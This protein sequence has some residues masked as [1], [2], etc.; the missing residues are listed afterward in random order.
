M[1]L[2]PLGSEKRHDRLPIWHHTPKT[3]FMKTGDASD[4]V[5]HAARSVL[6][7]GSWHKKLSG[8]KRSKNM[9]LEA[10]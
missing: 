5:S 4:T 10:E 2:R 3:H 1:T 6:S 9:V 7:S 8:I